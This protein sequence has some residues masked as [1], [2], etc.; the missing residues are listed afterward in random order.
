MVPEPF[1]FISSNGITITV[2]HDS[3]L[4]IKDET[5]ISIIG[6]LMK[7]LQRKLRLKLVGRKLFD[8]KQS[9]SIRSFEIWPG[10]ST[11]FSVS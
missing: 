6:R 10:F 9:I 11:S 2:Q 8:T 5:R 1:V 7:T 4:T 3:S